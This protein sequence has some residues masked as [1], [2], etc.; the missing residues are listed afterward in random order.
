L[1]DPRLQ[2]LGPSWAEAIK[3]QDYHGLLCLPLLSRQASVGGMC[4]YYPDIHK[5]TDFEMRLVTITANQAATAVINAKIFSELSL[6]KTAILNILED[7]EESRVRTEEE[8]NKTLAIITNFAEGLLLFDAENKLSLINPQAEKTFEVKER[9]VIGKTISG[10][11]A[12]PFIKPIATLLGKEKEI[13]RREVQIKENLALEVSSVPVMRGGE[14]MGTLII[15]YD[16]TREKLV[17]R[18][19][20]E[21][22]SLAAHQL[23]TPLS[24]IKWT[25]RILLDGDLGKIS[26]EQREFLEKTYVSNERMISLIN[27]LLNVT[28]IEEGRYLFR[29]TLTDLETV[30]QFV[31][32]S[33]KEEIERRRIKVEIKKTEEKLPPVLIDVEKIRLAI[34]NLLDNAIRY[35]LTGGRVTI[36]LSRGKKEIEFSIEDTGV[37]IP[38][39]QQERVFGK[40]F[41][42]ANVMRM[43]TEGSGLGLFI[44]K[45]VIEAHGGRVWF[46]SKENKGSTFH[47]TLPVKEELDGSFK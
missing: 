32:N 15:L 11:N 45:N 25:L 9:E 17:E 6:E 18:M 3:K 34:Q 10:L 26:E 14:E 23:R 33:N 30:A 44:V 19:K 12:F 41:R 39:D 27:D 7:A 35:S 22:V 36:Y 13:F 43:E 24:A 21:F 37:G 40:F 38:Q 31:V 46:E 5:F 20:T 42:A 47:F 4:L 29:P 28:R 2:E 16:V 1:K 8:K